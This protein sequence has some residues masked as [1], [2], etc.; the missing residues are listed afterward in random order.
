MIR[1]NMPKIIERRFRCKIDFMKPEKPDPGTSVKGLDYMDMPGS[2]KR[3]Y[4]LQ[5]LAHKEG[6]QQVKVRCTGQMG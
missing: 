6:Q 5:F 3:D 4:K 2:G 1:G